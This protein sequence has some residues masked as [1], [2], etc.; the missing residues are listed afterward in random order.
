MSGTLASKWFDVAH[1]SVE[2]V[3]RSEEDSGA[4]RVLHLSPV[5][6]SYW[7]DFFETRYDPSGSWKDDEMVVPDIYVAEHVLR[8][9]Y[10][11]HAVLDEWSFKV[12]W[13]Q[14]FKA[15]R[16]CD[17][18]R[19][20]EWMMSGFFELALGVVEQRD[21]IDPDFAL[22]SLRDLSLFDNA[23]I[24]YHKL[25]P[26][27]IDAL[28]ARYSDASAKVCT[29]KTII[30]E[31]SSLPLC[32]RPIYLWRLID[33]A[34]DNYCRALSVFAR[35]LTLLKHDAEAKPYLKEV[36]KAD[37]IAPK[38]SAQNAHK[39]NVLRVLGS[40]KLEELSPSLILRTRDALIARMN[41]CVKAT[42]LMPKKKK[43]VAAPS[44]KRSRDGTGPGPASMFD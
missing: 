34:T 29:Q 25:F 22:T 23:Y 18:I 38:G 39:H 15:L 12:N 32:I 37:K 41:G 1:A 14:V 3:L 43:K 19:V 13:D 30:D 5:M 9:F 8:T 28:L 6:L 40:I 31:S 35:D 33:P 26:K 10:A 7:S 27:L 21:E 20:R 4:K 44:A 11:P 42:V 16:F 36:L 17:M 2:I 24:G